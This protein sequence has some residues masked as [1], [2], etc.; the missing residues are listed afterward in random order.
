MGDPM[1]EMSWEDHLTAIAEGARELIDIEIVKYY[2][3]EITFPDGSTTTWSYGTG[4]GGEPLAKPK[5]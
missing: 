4:T 1:Y 5:D 2:T 3:Y